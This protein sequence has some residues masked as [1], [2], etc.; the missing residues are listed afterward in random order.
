VTRIPYVRAFMIHCP[1]EVPDRIDL[2]G[3]SPAFRLDNIF[4]ALLPWM[5]ISGVWYGRV[6]GGVGRT[7]VI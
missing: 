3:P 5:W 7:G 2:H 6:A 4:S 1:K